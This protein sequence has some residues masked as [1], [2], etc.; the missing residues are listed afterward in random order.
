MKKLIAIAYLMIFVPVIMSPV[1]PFVWAQWHRVS[2]FTGNDEMVE[3]C[4]HDNLHA[5]MSNNGDMYL[6]ALL[7]RFCSSK[8]K[9]EP[10]NLPA[11]QISVF[12]QRLTVDY[13]LSQILRLF[14][15]NKVSSFLP[16]NYYY[17]LVF[18]VFHPPTAC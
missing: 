18:S 15:H 3:S 4:E 2:V 11:P 7:K 13:P 12:V 17:Q 10:K 1:V 9:N 16:S 14:K 5:K 6:Q 8:K